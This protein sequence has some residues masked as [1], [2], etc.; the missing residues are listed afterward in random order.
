MPHSKHRHK[1]P[2]QSRHAPPPT[3]KTKRSAKPIMVV[4]IGLFGLLLA[5]ISAGIN[6]LWMVIGVIAGAVAGY[7]IGQNMDKTAGKK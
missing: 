4:F 6:Y 7:F 3:A 5:I 2:Q 1:H